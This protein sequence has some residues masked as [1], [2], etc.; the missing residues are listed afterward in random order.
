MSSS[1]ADRWQIA[2]SRLVLVGAGRQAG[3]WREADPAGP[4]RGPAPTRDDGLYGAFQ[5]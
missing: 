3:P 2:A 5:P 1:A 4:V